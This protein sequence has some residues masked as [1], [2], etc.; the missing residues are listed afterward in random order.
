MTAF[1]FQGLTCKK[2]GSTTFLSY[3]PFGKMTFTQMKSRN[4]NDIARSGKHSSS[5]PVRGYVRATVR[6]YCQLFACGCTH[7]YLHTRT[8]ILART[9]ARTN[10]QTYDRARTPRCTHTHTRART[11]THTDKLSAFLNETFLVNILP[12]KFPLQFE[13][14]AS[15]ISNPFCEN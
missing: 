3:C 15:F 12:L 13:C 11:C 5:A 4:R 2:R 9:H 10:M 8:G 14:F 6:M 1:V 7:Y